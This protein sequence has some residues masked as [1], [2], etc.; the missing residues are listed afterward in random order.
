[1]FGKL[2]GALTPMV[3]IILP[4]ELDKLRDRLL[5]LS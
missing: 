4:V 1:M 2:T 3:P 5:N